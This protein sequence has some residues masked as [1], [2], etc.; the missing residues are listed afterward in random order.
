MNN[1]NVLEYI[2]EKVK[3][4]ET[5]ETNRKLVAFQCFMEGSRLLCN[6]DENEVVN[7][8]VHT[9]SEIVIANSDTKKSDLLKIAKRFLDISKEPKDEAKK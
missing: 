7:V 6:L 4:L 3:S 9:I 1:K 8:Y 5:Y 2:E